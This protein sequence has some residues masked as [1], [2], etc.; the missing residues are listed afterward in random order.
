MYIFCTM[1]VHKQNIYLEMSVPQL[2]SEL[3]PPEYNTEAL[4]LESTLS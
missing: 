3:W 1:T 2:V 4:Q